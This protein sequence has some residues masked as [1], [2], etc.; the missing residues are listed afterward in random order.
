MNPDVSVEQGN[1]YNYY[2]P[3]IELRSKK[4]ILLTKGKTGIFGAWS[5]TKGVIGWHAL[6]DRDKILELKLGL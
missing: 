3:P 2:P 5:T 4:M 1:F 6:P